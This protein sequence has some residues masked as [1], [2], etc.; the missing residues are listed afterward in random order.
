MTKLTS[1]RPPTIGELLEAAAEIA[2]TDLHDRFAAEGFDDVRPGHD[3][4][5]QHLPPEGA[6]LTT[7]AAASGV[8]KQAVS[9]AVADLETRGYV[10]RVPDPED[11]RAKIIRPTERGRAAQAVAERHFAEVEAA[12]AERFGAENV[13][14]LRTLLE[15]VCVPE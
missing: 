6:R 10:E 3:C 12:W 4:V 11:R 8:S 5:M 13:E 14:A 9:E 2:V 7:L 1:T 15:Q